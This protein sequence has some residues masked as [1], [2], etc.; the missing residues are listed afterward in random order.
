[1][2]SNKYDNLFGEDRD[3]I[4]EALRT[5][6]VPDG[7][8][9]EIAANFFVLQTKGN[10]LEAE[11]ENKRD[12]F[13]ELGNEVGQEPHEI[14]KQDDSGKQQTVKRVPH[15]QSIKHKSRVITPKSIS[16]MWPIGTAVEYTNKKS[17]TI[18]IFTRTS[19][20]TLQVSFLNPGAPSYITSGNT[21]LMF[22][23]LEELRYDERRAL[24]K[25]ILKNRQRDRDAFS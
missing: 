7:L 14:S 13:A 5:Y 4:E 11:K 20:D 17:G 9:N 24:L 1:M 12:I 16:E 3:W 23:F 25:K 6:D 21:R 19:F 22:S 8:L 18:R 10:R 15:F 2:K